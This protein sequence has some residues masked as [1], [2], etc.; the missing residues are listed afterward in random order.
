MKIQK[1]LKLLALAL[2]ASGI[3]TSSFAITAKPM[4]KMSPNA[5]HEK[6]V[7]EIKSCQMGADRAGIKG[8]D[9]IT[10]CNLNE[11]VCLHPNNQNLSNQLATMKAQLGAKA[12]AQREVTEKQ[13]ANNAATQAQAINAANSAKA[14]QA[15]VN[16]ETLACVNTKNSC[17]GAITPFNDPTGATGDA[18]LTAYTTCINKI[19]TPTPNTSS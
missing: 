7:G 10:L 17:L 14:H 16:Y 18:C 9:V 15:A 19:S 2:I 6:C 1:S 8:G 3:A 11:Q 12:R 4:Q 5:L 13:A